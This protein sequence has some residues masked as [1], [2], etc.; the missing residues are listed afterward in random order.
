MNYQKSV[1]LLASIFACVSAFTLEAAK[2]YL[3][4]GTQV[5]EIDNEDESKSCIYGTPFDKNDDTILALTF[6]TNPRT[7][8]Y[9]GQKDWNETF[10]YTTGTRDKWTMGGLDPAERRKTIAMRVFKRMEGSMDHYQLINFYYIQTLTPDQRAQ[11]I[12]TIREYHRAPEAYPTAAE[13]AAIPDVAPTHWRL[14]GPWEPIVH[15][16]TPVTLADI[17]RIYTLYVQ[18]GNQESFEQFYNRYRHNIDDHTP[19]M[20]TTPTVESAPFQ[21][22]RLPTPEGLTVDQWRRVDNSLRASSGRYLEPNNVNLTNEQLSKIITLL[23]EVIRDSVTWLDVSNNQLTTLPVEVALLKNLNQINIYGNHITTL[24]EM[25]TQLE[26]LTRL[27]IDPSVMLPVGLRTSIH[28]DRVPDLLHPGAHL[29][30]THSRRN[31]YW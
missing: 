12:G 21:A 25:V 15:T 18:S 23:P 20:E 1:L 2:I 11:L 8:C 4:A 9:I 26:H 10:R 27:R 24:P 31:G 13:I 16:P 7:T 6:D 19:G 28:I 14:G 29:R 3:V 30:H 17:E 22:A 5:T